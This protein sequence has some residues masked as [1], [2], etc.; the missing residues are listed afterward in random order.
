MP[1]P[2]LVHSR[3]Q[4]VGNYE[5]P[6]RVMFYDSG[7]GIALVDLDRR[8]LDVN[9][10]FERIIGYSK[11]ELI[12]QTFG[13]ILYPEDSPLN[14][15]YHKQLL[16][17]ERESY[18]MER[19]YIRK[20]G[21]IVWTRL[22]VSLLRDRRGRPELTMGVVEDITE[23]KM[24]EGKLLEQQA[25]IHQ[26]AKMSALG[27]MA[28]GIAHEINTPLSVI[29]FRL[30]ALKSNPNR[31]EVAHIE[32]NIEHIFN[33][34]KGLQ[35]F[36][37]QGEQDPFE[38]MSVNDLLSEALELS[39]WRIKHMGIDVEVKVLEKDVQLECRP[40]QIL[41]VIVN[42][43]NNALDAIKELPEK[44]IGIEARDL[45]HAVEVWVT[46]SGK[47]IPDEVANKIFRSFVTTKP[48]GKGTGLGL[49]IA[50]TILESHRGLLKID[51]E[52]P[53]TRFVAGLPKS[54]SESYFRPTN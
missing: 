34:I 14:L 1:A 50:K 22:T 8:I 11:N 54:Q 21:E 18:H 41:Q 35:A 40:T 38:R 49:N 44:W 24:A 6:F 17:G 26:S 53:N 36:A 46:D 13:G 23:Q 27:E 32:K 33:I 3:D 12:G 16:S 5:G 47:G 2:K 20:T 37:R 43:I 9:P 29:Q 15:Q 30:Q 28:S 42:L 52:A 31:E 10:A 45:G 39:S 4:I 48:P 25:Q 51:K 19:R 7:M